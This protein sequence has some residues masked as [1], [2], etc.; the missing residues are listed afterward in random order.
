VGGLWPCYLCPVSKTITGANKIFGLAKAKPLYAICAAPNATLRS[1]DLGGPRRGIARRGTMKLPLQTAQRNPVT[2]THDSIGEALTPRI[3]LAA[4]TE[5]A[6]GCGDC[7]H[8][9]VA[10]YDLQMGQYQICMDGALECLP[11]IRRGTEIR[12]CIS[13]ND[14]VSEINDLAQQ[15]IL[16]GQL[17]GQAVSQQA[18]SGAAVV[19]WHNTNLIREGVY[20]VRPRDVRVREEVAPWQSISVY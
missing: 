6:Q 9:T 8:M 4:A 18:A 15:L 7:E 11:V 19:M 13:R 12:R 16:A 17:T 10:N 20:C 3:T 1:L 14:L 2:R 5:L